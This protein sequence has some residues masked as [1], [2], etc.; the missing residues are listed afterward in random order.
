[1]RACESLCLSSYREK[2]WVTVEPGSLTAGHGTASFQSVVCQLTAYSPV[3]GADSHP[4]LASL[5][6][7]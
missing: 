4:F 2:G 1:M 5:Q 3:H 6:H 7:G